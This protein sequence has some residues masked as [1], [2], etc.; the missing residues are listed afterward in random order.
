M[1]ETSN[2]SWKSVISQPTQSL[3][4]FAE[5][6][7][8]CDVFKKVEWLLSRENGRIAGNY[9]FEYKVRKFSL[10]DLSRKSPNIVASMGMEIRNRIK[11]KRRFPN[12]D[13]GL[14]GGRSRI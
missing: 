13:P 10:T 12:F 4:S 3:R 7:L 8:Q 11:K 9:L 5:A 1:A 14:N 6:Y 2:S